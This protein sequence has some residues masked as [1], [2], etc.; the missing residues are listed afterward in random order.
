MHSLRE[1]QDVVVP[2]ARVRHAYAARVGHARRCGEGCVCQITLHSNTHL[3]FI[4]WVTNINMPNNTLHYIVTHTSDLFCG[5]LGTQTQLF[6]TPP[7]LTSPCQGSDL[8]SLGRLILEKEGLMV[9]SR[10]QICAAAAAGD[11]TT[12]SKTQRRAPNSAQPVSR[13]KIK[14]IVI[15]R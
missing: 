15:L 6:L 5:S 1:P 4:L 14:F 11:S 3:R 10:W 12:R 2:I 8:S 9:V 7:K 13:Q